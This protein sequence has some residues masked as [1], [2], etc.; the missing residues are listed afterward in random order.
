MDGCDNTGSSREL[1]VVHSV[2]SAVVLTQICTC[3]KMTRPIHTYQ[4]QFPGFDMVPL[5]E[6]G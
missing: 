5:G 6:T 4:C 3:D 2:L 1:F